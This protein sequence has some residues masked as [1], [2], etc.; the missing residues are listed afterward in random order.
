ME[1]DRLLNFN[2]RPALHKKL[3]VKK[4]ALRLKKVVLYMLLKC[5]IIILRY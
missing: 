2:V 4:M 5:K 3:M 1:Q